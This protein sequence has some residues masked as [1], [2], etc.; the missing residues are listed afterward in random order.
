M[1]AIKRVRFLVAVR[2]PD[3]KT[4]RRYLATRDRTIR[5]HGFVTLRRF[6]ARFLEWANADDLA[7]AFYE[8]NPGWMAKVVEEHY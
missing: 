7:T 2:A 6:A 8:N 4:Y 3:D 1:R 5:Q